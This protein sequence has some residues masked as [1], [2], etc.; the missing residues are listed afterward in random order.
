[1]IHYKRSILALAIM[2]G[3]VAFSNDQVNC[4]KFQQKFLDNYI[5]ECE[6]EGYNKKS[7]FAYETN[8]LRSC[9]TGHCLERGTDTYYGIST[10]NQPWSFSIEA[11]K[12][13][14]RVTVDD[15]EIRM[16]SEFNRKDYLVKYCKP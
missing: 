3:T 13:K 7:G 5:L 2:A 1:M 16:E 9:E 6:S 10:D 4:P 15:N 12:H 14:Y 11:G 8:C